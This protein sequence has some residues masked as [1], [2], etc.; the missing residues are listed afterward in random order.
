MKIRRRCISGLAA[1]VVC[2][3]TSGV[4]AQALTVQ[5]PV[6]ETFGVNTV[7]SVPDRGGVLLGGISSGA[8]SNFNSAFSP[9][10]SSVGSDRSHSTAWARVYIHDFD[11]IDEALLS[12]PVQR[13]SSNSGF[14]SPLAARAASQLMNE[15]ARGTGFG[16]V[17]PSGV[18]AESGDT[19]NQALPPRPFRIVERGR[20]EPPVTAGV[21][22][23]SGTESA[24]VPSQRVV[25]E[26]FGRQV[27]RDG[28]S[29]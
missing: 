19:I 28:A 24:P 5:Q 14:R 22:D 15:Q 12:T 6:V 13:T 11:A 7:V 27:D 21:P 1:I 8:D 4:D 9:Y 29:R 17:R 20:R 18:V 23:V 26:R 16:S 25:F 2:S 3:V 10:G